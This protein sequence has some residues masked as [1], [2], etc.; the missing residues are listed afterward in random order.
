[1]SETATHAR[2]NNPIAWD[3]LA[4]LQYIIY[5]DTL[6][7]QLSIIAVACIHERLICTTQK[8]D[9]TSWLSKF[10]RI[11]QKKGGHGVVATSKYYSKAIKH[12]MD[13]DKKNEEEAWEW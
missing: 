2:K 12:D 8:K 4:V 5:D 1:M 9:P 11:G 3:C 7:R 13:N 10:S 6:C